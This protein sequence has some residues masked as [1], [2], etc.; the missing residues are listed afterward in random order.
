[1]G[2]MAKHTNTQ[3]KTT[4]AHKSVEHLLSKEE[5]GV[6][7]GIHSSISETQEEL[8]CEDLDSLEGVSGIE[9]RGRKVR[10]CFSRTETGCFCRI[11]FC[12]EMT[13]EVQICLSIANPWTDPGQPKTLH[14]FSKRR[15]TLT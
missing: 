6:R 4:P 8:N 13:V 11:S 7:K 15:T 12:K 3:S 2:D 1:M 14:S 9:A 10:G 5:A